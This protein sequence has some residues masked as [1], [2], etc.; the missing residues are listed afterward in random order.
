VPD[1]LAYRDIY[2]DEYRYPSLPGNPLSEARGAAQ[3][4]LRLAD[5]VRNGT[6]R[7][8]DISAFDRRNLGLRYLEV[9]TGLARASA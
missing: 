5:S 7:P 1:R 9:I 3:L 6:V 4:L 2:P 8:P